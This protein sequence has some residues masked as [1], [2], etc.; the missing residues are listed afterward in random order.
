VPTLI[1]INIFGGVAMLLWGLQM[2]RNGMMR[3]FGAKLRDFLSYSTSN[4]LKSFFAGLMFTL[5]LQSSTATTLIV[6]S[7]LSSGLI[8]L[9]A[10]IAVILGA[11]T[12]TTIVA[13]VLTFDLSWLASLLLVIGYIVYQLKDKKAQLKHIGHVL[14]GLGLML[15]ALKLVKLT[16][17]PL[18]ESELFPLMLKPLAEDH[19]FPIIIAGFITWMF[20]S[21]LAMVLLIAALPLPLELGLAMVLGANIGGVFPAL[22]ATLK[23][24]E[25]SFRLPLANLFVRVFGVIVAMLAMPFIPKV[26]DHVDMLYPQIIVSFHMTFNIVLGIL[27]LPFC[28][29][30]SGVVEKFGKT[31]VPEPAAGAPLYLD[32]NDLE[33]PTV[34]LSNA[35]REVLRMTDKL[36]ELLYCVYQLFRTNNVEILGRV[37]EMD[38]FIDELYKSIKTYLARVGAAGVD[39]ADAERHLL[40]LSYATSI[41]HAGDI[42]DRSLI[43]MARKKMDKKKVFS[44]EGFKD[45]RMFFETTL[46][47]LKL[48]RNVFITEDPELARRLFVVKGDFKKGEQESSERHLRRIA[49]GVPETLSTSSMHT[50][51]IRDLVRIQ[52]LITS[53]SYPILERSGQL[54]KT[55]LL[56]E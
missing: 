46:D 15:M 32:N 11:D 1:L 22:F 34:A 20:H 35:S 45:I 25:N 12:G 51:I 4:R 31:R 9:P 36:E 44:D 19:I 5:V 8:T 47:S 23:D 48:S 28:R 17:A 14:I 10:A 16:S 40:I 41:E 26:F 3:A 49:D 7:F 50:D 38:D 18:Q 2:V 37:R 39:G 43:H 53:V 56:A 54:R 13:Q 24:K 27:F 33:I 52:S 29:Q 30:L 42:V 55:R 6:S 21:S